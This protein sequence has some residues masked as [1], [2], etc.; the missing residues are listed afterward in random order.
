MNEDG[1][2]RE[3]VWYNTIG[4]AY[5]PIAFKFAKKYDPHAELFYNDY[6]LEYN[7]NKTLGAKRIVRDISP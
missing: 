2:Y 4:E 7:G 6:N 5:L 3:S 1:T